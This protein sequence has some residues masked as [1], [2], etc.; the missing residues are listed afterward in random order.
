MPESAEMTMTPP[1]QARAACD[2]GMHSMG[3][4]RWIATKLVADLT[5]EQWVHQV[6]PGANH[7]MF[8]FGH[9]VTYDGNFLRV[10]GGQSSVPESYMDLFGGGSQPS[11]DAGR[12]PSPEELLEVG[13]RAR[14]RLVSHLRGLN[15]EQ[16]LAPVEAGRLKDILPNLAHLP[17]FIALHEGMHMGQIMLA[18]RALG[19]PGVLGA[20]AEGKD[21]G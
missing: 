2:A 21:H 15:G 11:P 20:P 18:R 4:T 19:L 10:T 14:A 3:L 6:A 12:Y 8:N 1:G 17:G 9:L 13:E 7:P 5:P 16:L